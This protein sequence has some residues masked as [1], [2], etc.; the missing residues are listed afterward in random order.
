MRN[1]AKHFNEKGAILREHDNTGKNPANSNL[2]YPPPPP[3]LQT[4]KKDIH[5]RYVVPCEES[6]FRALKV[7]SFQDICLKCAP[8]IKISKPR[9][10]VC[11]RCERLRKEILDAVT[12][13]EK[14]S[15]ISDFKEHIADSKKEREYY[16]S[17]IEFG[18]LGR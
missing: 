2:S 14:L 6:E 5:K 16:R 17:C 3:N 9:D 1:I 8:H 12:E 11:H 7:S 18:E 15:D 13:E 4:P 10:D